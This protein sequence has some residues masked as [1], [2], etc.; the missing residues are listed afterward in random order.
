MTGHQAA[1]AAARA[2][3]PA[4]KQCSGAAD[5]VTDA[6][7]VAGV[8]LGIAVAAVDGGP[9]ELFVGLVRLKQPFPPLQPPAALAVVGVAAASVVVG[10]AAALRC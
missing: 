8:A 5:L 1:L 3:F 4:Q 6:L 2:G 10:A 9:L 7:D